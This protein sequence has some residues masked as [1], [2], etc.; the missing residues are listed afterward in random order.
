MA[1]TKSYGVTPPISLAGPTPAE[2]VLNDQLIQELKKQGNFE[3]ESETK[4][5]IE[6]LQLLQNLATN[7][8]YKVSKNK[9]MSEGMAKDAGGK[10]FTYGSY[11][12]GVYGPGS[13]IDTL[14][15]VPKHVTRDDFFTVFDEL[16]RTR[17]E[18]EEIAPVPDAFVPIIKVKI[19]GIEID[20]IY[21]KLDLPQV[22]INLTLGDKNLLRN[23]D[24]KDLRSLNGTRVTD[25]ILQ[26]VPKPVVFKLSLRAI[27]LWAQRRAIYANIFGFP[28]GV[29]WA[30]L[31]ARIC[32]LYPNAVS[33]VIVSKFFH[34]LTQWNWPQPVLLKPIEDGPLQVRV[35]NPRV[36]PQD[37]Q[38]R[39]PVI[40][41]AYP[42]MCATHNITASTQKVILNE[43]QRGSLIMNDI[44]SHKKQWEDLFVK[45]D[46]FYKYKFYLNIIA[47]T[48]G[49][50]EQHLKWS[51]LVESKLRLLV[52]KLENF[53]GIN[54]A[55]PYVKTF[56][57]SYLYSSDEELREIELNFGNFSKESN[58]KKFKEITE[59][60]KEDPIPE[61]SKI[62]HFT[63]LYIG[64]DITV[65]GEDKK[66]DIHVPCNDFFT[67]CR[68]FPD[69]NDSLIYGLNIKHVKLYDLP[70]FVYG[71]GETRPE[72]PNKKRK[73]D[74]NGKNNKKPKNVSNNSTDQLVKEAV[75]TVENVPVV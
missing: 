61:G 66:F 8:V 21:A 10:I 4:K 63:S 30:M 7:F 9:N 17:S 22:P 64:L 26:L 50:D 72:K 31:V 33:S 54:L 15:V 6:V 41:P 70:S 57:K 56:E 49:D 29:A 71:E 73:G 24:E 25:E 3:S 51:G 44:I 59:E 34:I 19:S 1:T 62:I 58:L 68:G 39:M 28:G 32:Q 47:F 74:K 2:N 75:E 69:Y 43:L 55:H 5:R 67:L 48:R 13:D 65:S 40:T 42:S 20:L 11:R 38:H 23:L 53:Q 35:W 45:H 36:Y 46:F 18:L 14:V 27:K 12:L 60:N 37:R 52:Q 16:L